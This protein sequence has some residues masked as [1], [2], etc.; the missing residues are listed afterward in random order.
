V[1]GDRGLGG[2]GTVAVDPALREG[3]HHLVLEGVHHYCLG[4]N[5]RWYGSADVVTEWWQ[6]WL[7][8]DLS[9]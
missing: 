5:R 3:S 6:K 8:L 7:A 9:E 2:D 4:G 1:G